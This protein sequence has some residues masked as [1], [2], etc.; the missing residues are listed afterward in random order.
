MA[1]SA[2]G[3]S[4]NRV[5]GLAVLVALLQFLVNLIG[6]LWP[7][8][9]WLRPLTVFYYYQPQPMI[10][11]AEWYAEAGIWLRLAVLAAVGAA[12]ICW[13]SGLLPPRSARTLVMAKHAATPLHRYRRLRGHNDRKHPQWHAMARNDPH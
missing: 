5:L 10:L 1:L 9:E 13:L 7:P 11:H 6:Q 2:A 4:R 12:A 8:M 3:R